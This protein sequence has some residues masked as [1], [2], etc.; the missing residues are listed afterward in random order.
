MM[1]IRGV[2]L[3]VFV[4][5]IGFVSASIA[6]VDNLQKPLSF[7]AP[8][9]NAPEAPSPSD[10]VSEDNI[11]VYDDQVIIDITN[12]EWARFTDTNSMDPVFDYGSNAI[13]IVPK[14]PEQLKAGDIVSYKSSYASGI[15]IHRIIETGKDE[16]GWFAKVK[17]DNNPYQDPEKVR[18]SQIQRVVVAIIY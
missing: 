10:W 3:L 2:I 14:K 7:I 12:P 11:H 18:F 16:D 15:I 5:A 1:S 13:E 17:G 8:F 4:F 9:G 6:N